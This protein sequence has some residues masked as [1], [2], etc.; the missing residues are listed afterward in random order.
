MGASSPMGSCS[1][2]ADRRSAGEDTV[3]SCS[4]DHGQSCRQSEEVTFCLVAQS[5]LEPRR[6]AAHH[7]PRC[8]W[9][10][11]DR[12]VRGMRCSRTCGLRRHPASVYMP[13]SEVLLERCT[14]SDI[15]GR[16]HPGGGRRRRPR[17]SWIG[18]RRRTFSLKNVDAHALPTRESRTQVSATVAGGKQAGPSFAAV[19]RWGYTPVTGPSLTPQSL[20]S[21]ITAHPTGASPSHRPYSQRSRQWDTPDV[22][23]CRR[24]SRDRPR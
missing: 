18:H 6:K 12:S 23:T 19:D 24:F 1:S 13:G 3:S 21:I 10:I 20:A 17:I 14:R 5:A 16:V 2:L 9:V 7:C 8:Y 4:L 11:A 15:P 22:Y